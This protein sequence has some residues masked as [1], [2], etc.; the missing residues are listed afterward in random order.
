MYF[1]RRKEIVFKINDKV[2]TTLMA[3][4]FAFWPPAGMEL[5]GRFIRS[6]RDSAQEFSGIVL[7]TYEVQHNILSS[8]C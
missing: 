2:L 6:G 3:F 4:Y 1:A 7:D 5:P 8:R